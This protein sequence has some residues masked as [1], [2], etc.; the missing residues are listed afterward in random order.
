MSNITKEW[1]RNMYEENIKEAKAA[2]SNE[3]LWLKGA[4]TEEAIFA[5]ESNIATLEEYI[6]ELKERV[7]NL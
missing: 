5:H 4:D 2:I 3:R 7:D 6:E 1:F